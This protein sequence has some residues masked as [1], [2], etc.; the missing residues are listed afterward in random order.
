[1]DPVRLAAFQPLPAEMV[2]TDHP[3]TEPKVTLGR[4]LYFEKRLSK[5]QDLSCNSCHGLDTYGADGKVVSPGHKQQN[6][7]RNSPTVYN[8][9]L[10][11]A[12]FWDGRE[13]TVE[14]QFKGPLTNPVEMASDEKRV[15]AV[16]N[17]MPEYVDSFKKAFPDDKDAVTF[18][19][20][21]KAIGAFERKLVTPGRWDKFLGGDKTALTDPEKIGLNAFLD[22]G[23]LACHSGPALG[24]TMFQKAGLIAPWP[25][26]KDQGRFDLTKKDDDKM[27][28][29]T[30]SLRNVAK[31]APY[32]HDGSVASLEEAVK[33][34][35]KLQLGRDLPADQ[36]KSI[37]T[38]LEALTGDLPTELIKE[39]T[40]PA[41]TK[42]TPKA[43]KT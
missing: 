7:T 10:H 34:M 33:I 30:P 22:T 12:Q 36:A 6:G 41:S 29:K 15:L 42:K 32:F 28:F 16:L 40:L 3:I 5:G 26:Q 25:N 24:G 39:P 2:S 8:A 19:N 14:A 38:F 20:V 17:S 9:A 11:F 35:A 37:T 43:D 1:V 21:G 23:C 27:M 18:V 4:M 13:P 31:T